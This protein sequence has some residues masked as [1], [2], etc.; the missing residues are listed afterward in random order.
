MDQQYAFSRTDPFR[1]F[2]RA[3]ASIEVSGKLVQ[4]V[5]IDLHPVWK[6]LYESHQQTGLNLDKYSPPHPWHLMMQA[7]CG[8]IS[9]IGY[10][11]L[12]WHSECWTRFCKESGKTIFDPFIVKICVLQPQ[13]GTQ[14]IWRQLVSLADS[15][16]FF[17]TLEVRPV[18]RAAAAASA[19]GGCSIVADEPGT[20]GGFLRDQSGTMFGLT[21]AHVAQQRGSLVNVPDVSGI[22]P[23]NA[24]VAYTTYT[25]LRA[26]TGSQLCNP[27]DEDVEQHQLDAALLQIPGGLQPLNTVIGVGKIGTIY[28]RRHFQT[29]FTAYMRGAVSGTG[30]YIVGGYSVMYRILFPNGNYYCFTNLYEIVGFSRAQL[31]PR[32]ATALAPRAQTGDSGAWICCDDT[33]G[34][35]ALSG[36]LIAADGGIGF[37]TFTDPL[38]LWSSGLGHHLAV[39]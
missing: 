39:F 32:F 33:N 34:S 10:Y 26:Q 16:P 5:V 30:K 13:A 22:N 21:C 36:T 31:A 29:G 17:T 3:L 23:Q 9:E 6:R 2:M 4:G 35:F 18:A 1:A 11:D 15:Q 12:E 37:A 20:L 27:D 8:N 38:L 19:E 24:T 14:S 28:G 25:S 7:G